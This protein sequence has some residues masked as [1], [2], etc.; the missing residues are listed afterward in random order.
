MH[1]VEALT[2]PEDLGAA[3]N[4]VPA[5]RTYRDAFPRSTRRSILEWISAAKTATTRQ[6]RIDRTVSDA[7]VDLRAKQWGGSPRGA[8]RPI[9]GSEAGLSRTGKRLLVSLTVGPVPAQAL[10]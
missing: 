5:A 6:N 2:E 8:P 1:E 9:M 7:S 3:L 4:A 10:V